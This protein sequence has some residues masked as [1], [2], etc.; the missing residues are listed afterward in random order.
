MSTIVVAHTIKPR[1]ARRWLDGVVLLVV[2]AVLWQ[3]SSEM[4]GPDVLTTPW[5]TLVRAVHIVS[6]PDFPASLYVTAFAFGS[7]FL[8]SAVCGCVSACCSA[9]ASWPAT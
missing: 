6:D 2:L 9:R 5:R 1:H 3:V 7:A 4:L 8:I